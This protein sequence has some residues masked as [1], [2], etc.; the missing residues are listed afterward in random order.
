MD[1]VE[2]VEFID[3]FADLFEDGAGLFFG[4]FDFFLHEMVQISL[5]TE[6]EE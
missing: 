4:D 1:D 3:G 5:I 2:L 6:L